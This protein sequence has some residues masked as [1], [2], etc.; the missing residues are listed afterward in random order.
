[1]RV[2]TECGTQ[3]SEHAQFCKECGAS[4][5]DAQAES[6]ASISVVSSPAFSGSTA[7]PVS[8]SRK[9]KVFLLLG[10]LLLVV[11]FGGY[12][13]G[14]YY[15]SEDRLIGRFE[16]ALD[17]QDPKA[18]A[19]FLTSKDENLVIDE[20]SI[21]GFVRYLDQNPD[22]K[23]GILN[24]LREQVI[25]GEQAAKD[26]SLDQLLPGFGLSGVVNLEKSGKTLFYNTYSLTMD[27]VYISVETN[28][29]GTVLSVNGQQVAVADRPNFAAKLGP[30]V[31]GLYQVEARFKNEFIDLK[32]TEDLELLDANTSY[33]AFLKLEGETVRWDSRFS[34]QPK[35]NGR[36]YINGKKVEVNPFDNPEFGPVTTD[37]S[38]TL[39]VEADFPWG[40]VKSSEVII[41]KKF[42]VLDFTRQDNIQNSIKDTLVKH[43]KENLAAFASGDM[44]KLTLSTDKYISVLQSIVSQF[45]ES[46]YAYKSKYIGTVFDRGSMD[47]DF[48]NGVWQMT[49]V[50][51][52]LIEAATFVEGE[53]PPLEMQ[54]AFSLTGLVYDED[55][56]IWRVDFISNTWGFKTNELEEYKEEKPVTYESTWKENAKLDAQSI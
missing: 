44:D 30:Y 32:N 28:F 54:E 14:Q 52:P 49:M 42:I 48:R 15:T 5:A 33:A 27:A 34:E 55:Q 39:A 7:A 40:T 21:A 2:C 46:G 12:K 1:M 36:L 53:S 19:K 13:A 47:L 16:Q 10:M 25:L 45:K 4:L 43:A 29:A 18:I 23:Q 37:G 24:T 20:K 9:Q 31:P 17:S 38:M 11:L 41:D 35:L 51:Q 6:A 26:N 50:T 22:E 3:V 8:I 56:K